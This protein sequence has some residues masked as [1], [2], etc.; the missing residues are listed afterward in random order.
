MSHLI[1]GI[2]ASRAFGSRQTGTERYAEEVIRHLLPLGGH[3]YRLYLREPPSR[4]LPDGAEV[5]VL[6][7]PRLW[8]HLRLGPEVALRP[9][10][11]LF[12]PAHVVP[13]GVRV[14][15]VV[16]VHDLGHRHYPA[17]HTAAQRWYLEW[18]TR[19][20]ARGATVVLA[21][22]RATRDDLVAAYGTAPE[23]VR[24]C[25]LGVDPAFAPATARDV[26]AARSAVGLPA[27]RTYLVH[28][29]T[30]QP[31]KN[32][33]RLLEAFAAVADRFP[34]LDVVLAGKPGWLDEDLAGHAFRLG[35]ADR[36]RLAGYVERAHLPG[37]LSGA[38]GLVHPSLYEGFGL[39]VLEA[40]AC[41]TPVIAS[42]SASLPE[43]VGD[44]GLLVDP[45]DTAAWSAAMAR[46]LED[47][48]LRAELA[49]RGRERARRFTWQRCAE[50]VHAAIQAAAGGTP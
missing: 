4:P 32:L 39:T 22:S 44:A 19:R 2:D 31:R 45:T 41:A 16:T 1:V 9:P 11:V 48:P 3:R 42:R 14:P 13:L 49:A 25:H 37:L 27:D 24:V 26:A 35:L 17:A 43:V 46:L 29:G 47:A 36:V 30:V 5:A 10:D 34:A 23:R 40:M 38:R 15:T 8:T 50:C 12:V 7:A 6:R 18:T 28:V 21:D 20:H 33:V